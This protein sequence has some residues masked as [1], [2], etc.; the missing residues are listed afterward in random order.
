[1]AIH[2]RSGPES[3]RTGF[4]LVEL[5]IV[6]AL[7]SI[8]SAV[9]IP[10]YSDSVDDANASALDENL[11]RMRTALERYYHQHSGTYPGVSK[12]QPVSG[13]EISDS[14]FI[15]QLTLYTDREGNT[16]NVLDRENYPYGPYI[17]RIPENPE[18]GQLKSPEG[19]VVI[20]SPKPLIPD[21]DPQ[22]GWKY[23]LITGELISNVPREEHN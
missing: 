17:L 20:R 1:M 15:D 21:K 7:I 2:L 8:L 11:H 5:L 19:V 16:T 18:A 6:I 22:K 3:G 10:Q 12:E 13:N 23:N 14:A 4:T 9:A